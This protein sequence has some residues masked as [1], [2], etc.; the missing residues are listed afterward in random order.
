MAVHTSYRSPEQ[1]RAAAI[2]GGLVLGAIVIWIVAM[3][4]TGSQTVGPEVFAGADL[5]AAP[6][7]SEPDASGGAGADA[8]NDS[9]TD[10]DT[11]TDADGTDADGTDA[12]G[13]D[14]DDQDSD[15]DADGTDVGNEDSDDDA[16]GTDAGNEEDAP[17]D[18]DDTTRAIDLEAEDGTWVTIVASLAG[19]DFTEAAAR[20]RLDTGQ[21]LLWS[22][23]YPSLNPGLW[24]IVEGPFD[25][26]DEARSAARRLGSGAYPRALTDDTDDRYCSLANGCDGEADA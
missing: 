16:D 26:E 5:E 7:T 18:A 23:D 17:A 21:V 4:T 8:G 2:L 24:V 12:D 3:V 19:D 13:T 20:D 1:R 15:T 11:D 25:T 6:S 22:S 14:A 9:D 10:S